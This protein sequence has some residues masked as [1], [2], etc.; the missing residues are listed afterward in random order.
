[1]STSKNLLRIFQRCLLLICL[2]HFYS[3]AICGGP[4]NKKKKKPTT[5]L[6]LTLSNL[7]LAD[8]TPL[9]A[10]PNDN[11]NDNPSF[12]EAARQINEN[13]GDAELIIDAPAT[14]L[15]H[16]I[17]GGEVSGLTDDGPF[18]RNAFPQIFHLENCSNVV[19]H[20][21]PE[22]STI[23]Q[24]MGK[25]HVGLFGLDGSIP[26]TPLWWNILQNGCIHLADYI[27]SQLGT[28][29]YS[30]NSM[31]G[32]RGF[33]VTRMASA[34]NTVFDLVYCSDI[35][36]ENIEIDGNSNH[37]WT[38]GNFGRGRNPFEFGKNYGIRLVAGNDIRLKNLNIHHMCLDGLG[39]VNYVPLG[40][41]DVIDDAIN[42]DNCSFNDNGRNGISW[43]GGKGLIMTNSN[44]NDNGNP[45]NKMSSSPAAGIDIEPEGYG[46][47][48]TPGATINGK[49]ENCNFLGNWGSGVGMGNPAYITDSYNGGHEFN[50][51]N[52]GNTSAVTTTGA[53]YA[54]L[55]VHRAC[56]FY[57]CNFY[58][59]T[60][61]KYTRPY[62]L[63]P[64][65]GDQLIFERD[66]FT[67]CYKG[68]L[69]PNIVNRTTAISSKKAEIRS[70]IFKTYNPLTQNNIVFGEQVDVGQ[71]EDHL[72][73][74]D[75]K[76][77]K[78][79]HGTPLGV[80][81]GT[82]FRAD[83]ENCEFFIHKLN[84][85]NA[86]YGFNYT[87]PSPVIG[88]SNNVSYYDN[89]T[90]DYCE[91]ECA[92]RDIPVVTASGSTYL[93]SSGNPN[94]VILTA[95]PGGGVW[96]GYD[97]PGTSTETIEV[98]QSGVYYVTV[99]DE[100]GTGGT[101]G[102]NFITVIVNDNVPQVGPITGYSSFC[103]GE[104]DTLHA[105]ASAG[106]QWL[107]SGIDI[108]GAHGLTLLVTEPGEYSVNITNACGTTPSPVFSVTEDF[109][110]QTPTINY[111]SLVICQTTPITLTASVAATTYQWY[112]HDNNSSAPFVA[113]NG[114]T[115]QTLLVL[116]TG[117][118]RV[119]ATNACGTTDPSE[120]VVVIN[121]LNPATPTISPAGPLQICEGAALSLTS[122]SSPNNTYTWLHN[123][124]PV[125]GGNNQTYSIAHV[126]SND[127]GN[128]SVMVTNSSGCSA[129][130]LP[131]SVTVNANPTTPTISTN[132]PTTFCSGV[133][134]VLTSSS[135]NSYLWNL[136]G[137]TN[138]SMTASVSGDYTV[139]V[140]NAAGCSAT[141]APITVTVNPTPS[142]PTITPPGPITFCE[143][144]S[145]TLT[146]SSATGNQWLQNYF[147]IDGATLP[148]YNVTTPGIFAVWVTNSYGCTAQSQP[149][150][151]TVN[152]NPATPTISAGGPTT[153]CSPGT[154]VLTSSSTTNN[155]WYLDGNLISGQTNPTYTAS[156]TGDYTVRVTNSSNCFAT[157][158]AI[159]VTVNPA[160]SYGTLDGPKN[161][162]DYQNASSPATYSITATS[163]SFYEWSTVGGTM[164]AP[165]SGSS[166]NSLQ[167]SFSLP[168]PVGSNIAV[169]ITSACDGTVTLPIKMFVISTIPGSP[170]AISY[171][172]N[173]KNTCQYYD[174][175][176]YVEL[177][178]AEVL[179]ASN[180][181][182]TLPAGVHC[183]SPNTTASV[184][185][186]VRT[187]RIWF[188]LSVVGQNT[189]ISVK[190][191]NTCGSSTNRT[192][193]FSKSPTTCSAPR[194][195]NI[196][197]M[198]TNLAE[199]TIY[200][201]P[202]TGNF[203]IFL[204][205]DKSISTAVVEIT[206]QFGE[207]VYKKKE[208]CNAGIIK[209]NTKNS[210]ASGMY[211]VTCFVNGQKLVKKL[212]ISK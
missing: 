182:W 198:N 119:T 191:G 3:I 21:D 177:S 200:P 102:S 24:M 189:T 179:Y 130:S 43:T 39:V 164:I 209:L 75:C 201:N 126:N 25:M 29:S 41:N 114:E 172:P 36:I 45:R 138:Q 149:V 140:T 20:S 23:I 122:S 58:G 37:M 134:L 2:M 34:P 9:I 187:I 123:G 131:T 125:S 161:I 115:H 47:A 111:T 144:S 38:G 178:I 150:T 110:L 64:E 194:M 204:N 30:C 121:V 67:D 186:G 156:T 42:I 91:M 127:A 70:C 54:A 99:P 89:Y 81:A 159:H 107:E 148:S 207:I 50:F 132:G 57:D 103:S 120:E 203:T 8:G 69:V 82:I 208:S 173:S 61:A 33:A 192:I 15:N 193:V 18:Y 73:V 175:D 72:Q 63:S 59:Y 28:S 83:I 7:T 14:P 151:V 22:K 46:N 48:G 160:F 26:P 147:Y 141:S 104:I 137:G 168:L 13:G 60:S 77:Y 183:I 94:S 163:A 199:S 5:H 10:S 212:I 174:A 153:F 136:N 129:T 85:I 35:T 154:V 158:T 185:E 206:N 53:S 181:I 124:N 1:M 170:G 40:G 27:N 78:F 133:S 76:F 169:K 88:S 90:P 71:V 145:V 197:T 19:I 167:A 6:V 139:T 171:S 176:H 142:T 211:M 190:S 202:T 195:A 66:T 162:C 205:N 109:P 184:I 79:N 55:I 44:C 101:I 116:H 56:K 112:R 87:D 31:N 100:C 80:Y 16:W 11:I 62:G 95:S 135:A 52:M 106:I 188:D 113:M 180:Y 146:S 92:R 196:A 4:E 93:C 96:Q 165:T 157:S 49:F 86:Y 17:V 105:P 68:N 143:G 155:Q 74:S 128:Y 152:S 97:P 84:T 98:T 166:V 32:L 118:Y 12:I 51:C 117:T 65:A 108:P 210:L